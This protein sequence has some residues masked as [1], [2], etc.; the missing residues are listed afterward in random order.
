MQSIKNYVIKDIVPILAIKVKGKNKRALAEWY[1]LSDIVT[2]MKL[3]T[4]ILM[5]FTARYKHIKTYFTKQ[6]AGSCLDK[7]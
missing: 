4:G 3:T 2:K 6:M 1:R 5:F 7:D